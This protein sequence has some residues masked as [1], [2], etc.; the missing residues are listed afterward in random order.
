MFRKMHPSGCCSSAR[1]VSCVRFWIIS[2]ILP[3][4]SI[5]YFVLHGFHA[6]DHAIDC[7]A[8]LEATREEFLLPIS[9]CWVIL[10]ACLPIPAVFSAIPAMSISAGSCAISWANGW[11]TA[12]IPSIWKIYAQ[13]LR[14]YAIIMLNAISIC[15]AAV[16]GSPKAAGTFK[17][18]ACK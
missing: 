5:V 12:N 6:S 3:M 14:I 4:R 8:Y 18:T 10:W 2:L 17:K 13:W 15:K 7:L 11:K 1:A 16:R 9:A